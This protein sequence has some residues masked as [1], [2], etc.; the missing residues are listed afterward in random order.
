MVNNYWVLPGSIGAPFRGNSY[1]FSSLANGDLPIQFPIA[2]TKNSD[3]FDSVFKSNSGFKSLRG[4]INFGMKT[5]LSLL[6]R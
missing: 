2:G 3:D 1:L 5:K 4:L 6:S